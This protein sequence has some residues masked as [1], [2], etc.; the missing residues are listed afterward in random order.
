MCCLPGP[1][2]PF[3]PGF[4]F[5]GARM[6]LNRCARRILNVLDTGPRKPNVL[7]GLATSRSEFEQ[8]IGQL[9]LGGFVLWRGR[10]KGR[11]LA[12]NGRRT[13]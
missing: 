12:L 3:G 4:L 7:S 11:L 6:P 1:F 13:A 5:C 9:F 8:A 10:T 2:I